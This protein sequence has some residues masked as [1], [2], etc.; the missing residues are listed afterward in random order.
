MSEEE[1]T[2]IS[3]LIGKQGETPVGVLVR[4]AASVRAI[5]D[6]KGDQALC[7]LDDPVL[8]NPPYP[9]NPA[10]AIAVSSKERPDE[11]IA[12]IQNELMELFNEAL[13]T[14][15]SVKK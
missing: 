9:D 13:R 5:Q 2:E 4:T 10:H 11:D 14:I 12:E 15:G 6:E 7:V 1:I 8:A 3:H